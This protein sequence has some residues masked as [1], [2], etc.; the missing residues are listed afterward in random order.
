MATE[1]PS[2][3]NETSCDDISEPKG[4][5][6]PNRTL[7][8]GCLIYFTY[9]VSIAVDSQFLSLYY[10]SR[11]FDGGTL[12]VLYSITPLTTFLTIPLWSVVTG[13]G[14]KGKDRTDGDKKDN[15]SAEMRHFQI[16]CA[17]I[18]IATLGQLSLAMLDEPIYMMLAIGIV[19]IF[20]SPVK[21][22]L[23]GI[24]IDHMEDRSEVGKVRLFMILGSGFGTNLGGRLLSMVQKSTA[25]DNTMAIESA[26]QII[27]TS[28]LR[29]L[30]L[31]VTSGFNLLFFA[32]FILTIPPIICIRQL[33]VAAT[34]KMKQGQ[35]CSTKPKDA[36]QGEEKAIDSE[37]SNTSSSVV[38]VTRDV[39]KHCFGNRNNLLFFLC[40]YVAGAS[41]GVSDTFSYLRYQESGCS[42]THMG[43]SRFLSSCAGGVMFWF[44]GRV[45]R[46]LGVQNVFVLSL[47]CAGV[48]FSLLKRMDHPYYAYIVD[49]IRGA[50]FGAFWSSATLYASKIGPPSLRSS[51]LLL[52]NGI[53]NGIGRSTGAIIA[54][55]FQAVFGTNNL[56]LYC[57]RINFALAL[58]MGIW[59]NRA[60][61]T[62]LIEDSLEVTKKTN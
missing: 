38:S 19:G 57:A 52:L 58:V 39:M 26:N 55:R 13:K 42:T 36:P 21:P 16:L 61:K 1:A 4:L 8:L 6:G 62:N 33:Q 24:L 10:K 50:T 44:S 14:A 34:M 32:R 41:G 27:G 12:G 56:F 29:D 18:V 45:T 43:Q 51:V 17:N 53:Y 20:Q 46:K 22:I 9:S 23:D 31:K 5:S 15:T 37:T 35:A 47:L 48:R 49:L 30:M 28:Y 59:Y 11:G 3:E 40:I 25:N 7:V 60:R 2:S 54:G